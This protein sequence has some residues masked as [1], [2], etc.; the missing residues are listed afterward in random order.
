MKLATY[1]RKD[2]DLIQ[3]A[4]LTRLDLLEETTRLQQLTLKAKYAKRFPPVQVD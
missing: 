2:D 3:A 4:L 1:V